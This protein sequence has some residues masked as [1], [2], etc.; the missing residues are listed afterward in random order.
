MSP[1]LRI[2]A[3][4]LLEDPQEEAHGQVA[5]IPEVSYEIAGSQRIVDMQPI[6]AHDELVS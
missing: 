3:P 2:N 5:V 1:G 4:T 6:V